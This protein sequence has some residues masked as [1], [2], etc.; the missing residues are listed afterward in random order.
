MHS[1]SPAAYRSGPFELRLATRELF[2]HGIRLDVQPKVFD[3]IVFL[4]EQRDRVVDKDE[5]LDGIWP[6]QVITETALTRAVMKARKVL[7]DDADRQRMIR[8]V[9][10][11]GYRFVAPVEVLRPQVGV[12]VATVAPAPAVPP[13]AAECAPGITVAGAPMRPDASFRPPS[14]LRW[15][16]MAAALLLLATMLVW[17][18]RGERDGDFAIAAGDTRV[19]VLPV[20]NLTGDATRDWMQLGLMSAVAQILSVGGNLAT[21]SATQVLDLVPVSGDDP[22]PPEAVTTLRERFRV[23]H[24]VAAELHKGQGNYR[25]SYVVHGPDGRQR[26]RSLIGA[27]IEA[28]ARGM[29]VDLLILLGHR[30]DVAVSMDDFV[31]ETYLRGRALRVQG[32]LQQADE[33]FRLASEQ[34]P[35]AFWPRYEHALTRRDLGDREVAERMLAALLEQGRRDGSPAQVRAAANSLAI[36]RMHAGALDE[37][38]VLLDEALVASRTLGDAEAVGTVL[39]NQSI[40][41]RRR[42]DLAAA[43]QAAEQALAV[44]ERAGLMHPS[45]NLLNALGQIALSEGRLGD[46]RTYTE[47]AVEA[48][49]LIGD[50]RGE[51]IT[52]NSLARLARREGNAALATDLGHQALALHRATGERR[53]LISTLLGLS[54]S[55]H[56]DGHLDLA[57]THAREALD[58]AESL[59]DLPYRADTRRRLAEIALDRGDLERAGSGLTEA[60]E[61]Y[62]SASEWGNLHNTELAMA[63]L[64]LARGDPHGAGSRAQKV[65]DEAT[66]GANAN[67]ASRAHLALTRIRLDLGDGEGALEHAETGFALIA[68]QDD[69]SSLASL[70]IARARALVALSRLDEAADLLADAEGQ[71]FQ[72]HERSKA[73][74]ELALARGDT[75]A[76]WAALVDAREHAR[77]RWSA[78]DEAQLREVERLATATPARSPDAE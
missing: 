53:G 74:A 13:V 8:T 21:L 11:R 58:A 54:L 42:G 45:G 3:L 62:R 51:A 67:L 49:R 16:G 9:H 50:R 78:R 68:D 75:A 64:E 77:Q 40:I 31:D 27:D 28:L 55:A 12:S 44:Y 33:M 25:V 71:L 2:R 18:W 29:G 60:M 57:E 65:L 14:T 1:P 36:A 15:L 38:S 37:A 7:D 5:M 22:L 43:R 69:R 46:G 59:G 35:E 24:V 32:E 66:D 19:A 17:L 72:R 56:A 4:I 70:R 10:S 39:A 61:L 63:E 23:S 20:R 48:F 26:R 41:A 6:R 47:R 76:A 52:L 30:A 73:V 34:A